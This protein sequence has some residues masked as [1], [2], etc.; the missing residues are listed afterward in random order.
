MPASAA[1][2]A[3]FFTFFSDKM[4]SDACT[5]FHSLFSDK[6]CSDACTICHSLFSDKLCSDACTI[7][8][9]RAKSCHNMSSS[10]N[11]DIHLYEISQAIYVAKRSAEASSQSKED[12]LLVLQQLT[13]GINNTADRHPACSPLTAVSTANVGFGFYADH[14]TAPFCCQALDS[15]SSRF[16]Q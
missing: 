13:D 1:M 9:E 14:C 6:L 12:G 10:T 3:Q 7:C 11:G 8:H 4:C 2:P 16:Q 15:L 5:I